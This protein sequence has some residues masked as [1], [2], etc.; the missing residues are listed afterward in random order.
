VVKW[1]KHFAK[2]VA[3]TDDRAWSSE[4]PAG[5]HGLGGKMSGKAWMWADVAG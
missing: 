5:V 1:R 4:K 3:E 2:P